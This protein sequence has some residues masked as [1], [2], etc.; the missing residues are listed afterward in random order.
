MRKI[1]CLVL[2]L[3]IT[4]SGFTQSTLLTKEDYLQKSKKQK[5]AGVILL[6]G[7]GALVVTGTVIGF[8][9]ARNELANIFSETDNDKKFVGAG[10]LLVTGLA[11][12]AGS[13]PFFIASGKNKR[14][15]A[16]ITA[17]IKIENT[18]LLLGQSISIRSYPAASLKISL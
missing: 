7:G 5:K 6:S 10:V 17:A 2:L 9:A 13:V 18:N 1:A 14:R 11:A 8:S 12:M 16:K 4:L 3:V 15:V